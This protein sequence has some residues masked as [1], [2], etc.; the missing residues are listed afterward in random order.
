M[1][2]VHLKD[3]SNFLPIALEKDLKQTQ[4]NP[5]LIKDLLLIQ[6]RL[7]TLGGVYFICKIAAITIIEI[8]LKCYRG[9]WKSGLWRRWNLLWPFSLLRCMSHWKW[10]SIRWPV[11]LLYRAMEEVLIGFCRP[12]RFSSVNVITL[13]NERSMKKGI[14]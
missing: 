14:F 2:S 9:G 11:S 13:R 5:C 1:R 12:T 6:Q 3:T 4:I 7:I 10:A 8:V